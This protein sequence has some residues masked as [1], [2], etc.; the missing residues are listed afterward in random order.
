M[1]ERI[2]EL[3]DQCSD[4]RLIEYDGG[5]EYV[6]VFDKEKFAELLIRE[7]ASISIEAD[8]TMTNQGEASAKAFMEY[9]GVEE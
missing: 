7:C 8:D 5:G 4:E 3:A 2:K 6:E 9:F 1:N